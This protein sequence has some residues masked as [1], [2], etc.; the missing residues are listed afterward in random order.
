MNWLY[1]T[2]A[3]EI[4]V[5]YLM[6][7]VFAGMIGTAFSILVRLELSA[8]GVQFL[9][10][11]HQL[12]NGA[13]SNYIVR[14]DYITSQGQPNPLI[15]TKSMSLKASTLSSLGQPIGENSMVEKLFERISAS[16]NS[17]GKANESLQLFMLVSVPGFLFGLLRNHLVSYHLLGTLFYVEVVFLIWSDGQVD[18]SNT[19]KG[20]YLRETI[21][22]QFRNSGS[23]DRRKPWGDGGPVVARIYINALRKPILVKGSRGISTKVSLPAGFE[24]LGNLRK[25][26]SNNFSH[27][28]TKVLE[29]LCDTDV[30]IAAYSK[31]TLKSS[32]VN[33]TQ[34]TYSETVD[35]IKIN[36]E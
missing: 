35:G 12:F 15:S 8:P 16:Y 29:L 18:L 10:G 27:V 6:F 7:S 21:G 36:K 34:R 19:K 22:G 1:S 4:S 11:D 23:P 28:N 13:P 32:P 31:L 26:N 25:E 14:C 24:K 9:A 2:N 3:K 30:L 5:L 17:Y 33:R 20:R